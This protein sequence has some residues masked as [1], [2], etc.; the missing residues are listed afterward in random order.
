[1]KRFSLPLVLSIVFFASLLV[2]PLPARAAEPINFKRA[3]WRIKN[4]SYDVNFVFDKKKIK[5]DSSL[6]QQAYERYIQFVENGIK[7]D[8]FLVV[9]NSSNADET[10]RIE[11]IFVDKDSDIELK[12]DKSTNYYYFNFVRIAKISF[13]VYKCGDNLSYSLCL[14]D[15][16]DISKYNLQLSAQYYS[17]VGI[18][19]KKPVKYPQNYDGDDFLGSKLPVDSSV[20][21]CEFHDVG[22]WF[23]G[24]FENF[25]DSIQGIFRGIVGLFE[26]LI[27]FLSHIFV[28]GDE[29]IFKNA[30]DDLSKTLSKKLGFLTFPFEFFSK[31]LS[32]FSGFISADD[33]SEWH[34]RVGSNSK[35]CQGFCFDNLLGNNNVCFKVGILE[36]YAPGIWNIVM[37]VVRLGFVLALVQV[38]H[39]KFYEVV[40]S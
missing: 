17:I 30:Y 16:S 6:S 3:S 2:V 39:R 19:S 21:R 18:F 29:N 26:R 7:N 40:E 36:Q 38:L 31:I 32:A 24:I 10:S 15:S 11:F 13:G 33:M 14:S 35:F 8:S 25:Q 5:R 27:E 9:R 20:Q 34:C 22:C 37:P 1:M 12:Y 23:R 28:P 4:P